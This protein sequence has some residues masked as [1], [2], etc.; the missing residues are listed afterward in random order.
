MAA[1]WLLTVEDFECLDDRAPDAITYEL[2]HGEL[3]EVAPVGG[4]HGGFAFDVGLLVG[5]VVHEHGLGRLYSSDT[6][7]MLARNPD[8]VVKPDVAY[9]RTERVSAEVEAL[10]SMRFPPDLAIEVDLTHETR[11]EVARKVGLYLT[12]GVPMTVVL[13]PKV[14]V[15]TVYRPGQDL[16]RLAPGDTFDGGDVLPGF[17]VA[18]V[19]VLR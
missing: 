1:T 14:R 17:R 7:F 9:V 10:G 2:I 8:V 4:L 18:V 12:A 16:I 13:E 5:N 19:D 6:R 15:M 11:R 3:V